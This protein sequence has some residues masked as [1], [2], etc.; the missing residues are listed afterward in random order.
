MY[1]RKPS[2]LFSFPL[3]MYLFNVNSKGNRQTF[4]DIDCVA[5]SLCKVACIGDFDLVFCTMGRI[6]LFSL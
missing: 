5:F 2:D 6:F 3:A 4:M 1:L